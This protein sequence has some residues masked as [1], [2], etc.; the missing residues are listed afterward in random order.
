MK[1]RIKVILV[2]LSITFFSTTIHATVVNSDV[3]FGLEINSQDQNNKVIGVYKG[4]DASGYNFTLFSEQGE[5]NVASFSKVDD[6]LAKSNDLDSKSAVGVTYE[7]TFITG[8]D[9]TK[10]ITA[11]KA[12]Y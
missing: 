12:Q 7:I 11:L 6:A 8:K 10:I 9:G 3:P 1:T 2:M 4:H 5:K